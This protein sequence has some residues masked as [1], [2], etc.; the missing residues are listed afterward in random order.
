MKTNFKAFWLVGCL[1]SLIT[2]GCNFDNNKKISNNS[3]TKSVQNVGISLASLSKMSLP[4]MELNN[5][6]SIEDTIVFTSP[7]SFL[8]F[9]LGKF[10][11]EVGILDDYPEL[12]LS[13]QKYADDTGSME[14]YSYRYKQSF[15]KMIKND[16]SGLFDIVFARLVDNGITLKNGITI[17]SLKANFSEKFFKSIVDLNKY[18]VVKIESLILGIKHIYTFKDDK[19][20][21]IIID[22]DYQV[23]KN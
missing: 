14:L 1:V 6:R 8:Y 12:K 16:E 4:E 11:K 15:I 5:F 7:T 2:L 22:S 10:K 23:D 18:N 21:E 3:S 9:P 19:L 20:V 17:G 13:H